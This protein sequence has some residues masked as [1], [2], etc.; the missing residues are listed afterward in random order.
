MFGKLSEVPAKVFVNTNGGL[1][2]AAMVARPEGTSS[3]L[4]S[5]NVTGLGKAMTNKKKGRVRRM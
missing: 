4:E 1:Q 5:I 3:Q 2:A